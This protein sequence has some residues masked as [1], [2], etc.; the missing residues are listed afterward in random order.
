VFDTFKEVGKRTRLGLAICLASPLAEVGK[1]VVEK[2]GGT[3]AV[4]SE[5]GKGTE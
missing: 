3:I 4:N 1:I 5:V 2:H